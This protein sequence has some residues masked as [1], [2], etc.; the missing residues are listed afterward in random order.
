MGDNVKKGGGGGSMPGCYKF[1][2]LQSLTVGDAAITKLKGSASGKAGANHK[3][4]EPLGIIPGGGTNT[5]SG[6][7]KNKGSYGSGT[8][9]A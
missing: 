7:P 8:P 9:N 2:N 6:G 3:H 1:R 4:G 5:G